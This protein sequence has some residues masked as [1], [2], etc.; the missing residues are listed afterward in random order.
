MDQAFFQVVNGQLAPVPPPRSPRPGA[1]ACYDAKP[2]AVSLH[3]DLSIELH[4]LN[5]SVRAKLSPSEALGLMSL[6]AYQVREV[7]DAKRGAA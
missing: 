5:F 6:L 2:V 4:G 7:V 3:H 1:P